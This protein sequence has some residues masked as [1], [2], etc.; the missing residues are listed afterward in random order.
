[1]HLDCEVVIQQAWNHTM[2]V[3]SPMYHL[4]EKIKT[5]RGALV[6]WSKITFG[7]SKNNLQEK[8]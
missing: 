3:G 8:H 4:F 1:M 6:R 5:C 2:N 7:Q